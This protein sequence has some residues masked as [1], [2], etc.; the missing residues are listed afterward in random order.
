MEMYEKPVIFRSEEEKILYYQANYNLF[1]HKIKEILDEVEETDRV[2]LT[3]ERQELDKC[4]KNCNDIISE[5]KEN[6]VMLPLSEEEKEYKINQYNF[7][8]VKLKHKLDA[9][10]ALPGELTE[11]DITDGDIC[12]FNC[13]VIMDDLRASGYTQEDIVF[14]KHNQIVSIKSKSR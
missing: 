9:L 14:D 13:N 4:F 6:N 5:M 1:N 12:M 8:S 3:I 7:Y 10:K 11:K 2:F